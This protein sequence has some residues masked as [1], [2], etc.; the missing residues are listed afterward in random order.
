MLFDGVN[1]AM[2]LLGLD[3]EKNKDAT[4]FS[5][6]LLRPLKRTG[7]AVVTIDHVTKSKD[8]RGSYA[9]GAQAKRA[10]I[11]GCALMVEVVQAFGRG[12]TGRLRLTVSKDRPGHVRA[13]SSGAKNAGTAVLESRDDG[14]VQARVEAPDLRPVEERG[15]FR[16]TVLM[17]RVS[18]YLEQVPSDSDGVSLTAIEKAVTGQAKALREAVQ[19]LVD[20]GHIDL[21][22]T[23]QGHKLHRHVRLYEQSLDPMAD[24]PR[25]PVLTP[26]SPRPG[27]GSQTPSPRPPSYRGTGD[28]A[29]S[30]PDDEPESWWQR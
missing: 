17:E 14:T 12:M 20:E 23:P 29:D 25:P 5:L 27:T 18:R 6:Q 24:Q 3:L 2:T 1:A 9:I 11:D 30:T 13:I 21:H 16:P 22:V 8:N 15:P 26:S 4:A 7:A 19:V 28:G 10:D